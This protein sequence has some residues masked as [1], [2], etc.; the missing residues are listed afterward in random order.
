M[1]KTEK[2]QSHPK[3]LGFTLIEML[4]TVSI[5]AILASVAVPSFT[6]MIERNRISSASNE[7]LS[8]LIL[9]RS[10]AVKR[11]QRVSI[12]VAN[13]AQDACDKN[14][15]DY[16]KGWIIYTECSAPGSADFGVINDLATDIVCDTNGD[17]VANAPEQKIKVHG[18]LPRISIRPVEA[19]LPVTLF[20]FIT[21]DF[22]G[23]STDFNLH[24]GK[25]STTSNLKKTI[26]LNRTGRVK[27]CDYNAAGC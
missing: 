27:V 16:A 2:M 25:D 18:E 22:S 1:I 4:V 12:C 13:A 11:S 10:E 14:L 7:F 23:R 20:D 9:T 21:Y 3:H 8:A 5:A 17:G 6:K 19:Q 15:D 24:V 26:D